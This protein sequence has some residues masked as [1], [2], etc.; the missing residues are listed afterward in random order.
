M[1]PARSTEDAASSVRAYP[2]NLLGLTLDSRGLPV[3][4]WLSTGY[5][6]SPR[7]LGHNLSEALKGARMRFAGPHS[8]PRGR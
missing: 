3:S 8:G 4:A 2:R 5:F 7:V 6:C 1:P